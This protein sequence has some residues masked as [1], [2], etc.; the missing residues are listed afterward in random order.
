MRTILGSVNTVL[1]LYY[2]GMNIS[3]SGRNLP[4]VVA[5]HMDGIKD[6]THKCY[7]FVTTCLLLQVDTVCH[8]VPSYVIYHKVLKLWLF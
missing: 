8:I 3:S 5:S 6:A 7:L 4:E 2:C 1:D